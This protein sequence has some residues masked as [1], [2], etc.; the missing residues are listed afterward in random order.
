MK[1]RRLVVIGGGLI[2]LLLIWVFSHQGEQDVLQTHQITGVIK[3]FHKKKAPQNST[4]KNK[5][6]P[7]GQS[8]RISIA[9][10]ELQADTIAQDGHARIIV[11]R[12]KYVEGDILPLTLKLYKN[13]TRRVELSNLSQAKEKGD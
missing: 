13:G 9:I 10:V 2:I 11:P 4:I 12:D 8:S 1:Q 3:E 5:G 6:T 7:V